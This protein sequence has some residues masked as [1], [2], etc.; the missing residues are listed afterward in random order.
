M[1]FI[2]FLFILSLFPK[3]SI[4]AYKFPLS[5]ENYFDRMLLC[6]SSSIQLCNKLFDMIVFTSSL[7]Q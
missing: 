3:D 6:T 5:I 2:S 1:L 4:S 7:T